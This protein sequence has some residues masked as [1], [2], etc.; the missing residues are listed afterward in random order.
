MA[1]ESKTMLMESEQLE[2]LR[3]EIGKTF[4]RKILTSGDCQQLCVDILQRTHQR[5]SFNTLR[6]LFHLMN[7]HHAT[8]YYTLD[9][10]LKYCGFSSYN[11]FVS[12]RKSH[13]LNNEGQMD[14]DLLSYLIMLF[15][16]T[17]V[18]ILNDVTY[19]S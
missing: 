18:T 11:D 15:K 8:S 12:Y 2:P 10:L 1:L 7:D 16:N 19:F 3:H 17:Q 4:G 9:I 13:A 6:R 5:I 14:S